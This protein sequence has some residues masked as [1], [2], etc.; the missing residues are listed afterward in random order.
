MAEVIDVERK[1][2]VLMHP[3][4]P[5]LSQYHTINLTAGCPYECRYCYAQSFRSYPGRGKVHFYA[6]T[7]DLLRREL[8]RKRQKP[9]LVYFSTACEPF[10]PERRILDSLYGTM[11][12]LLANGVFLL[13][14]TKSLIPS[15]F[16]QLFAGHPGLVHVQVG[17]T[18][19]DDRVRQLLEPN[20]A[21]V[22]DRLATLGSL[23]RRGT[24]AEVRMDPLIPG[25]TDTEQSL[26]AL[27]DA[28]VQCGVKQAAASYLFLRPG[29]SA[30]L[31]IRFGDWSFREMSKRLYTQ[32]IE[33]Y[34]GGGAIRIPSAEYRSDRYELLKDLCANRGITVQLCACKNPDLTQQCCHPRAATGHGEKAQ[35]TLFDDTAD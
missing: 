20:A 34:C 35:H 21:S 5:C 26:G 11:Q 30:R 31:G 13:I 8:P 19:V 1:S 24:R 15:Q 16:L 14:S 22:D 28:V 33:G 2:S 6:N 23:A 3:A 7:L 18:T 17:L 25:L 29:N 10:I 9:S 27:C 4:L 32:R 12:L